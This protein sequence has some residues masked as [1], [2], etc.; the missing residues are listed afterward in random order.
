M[1]MEQ[2]LKTINFFLLWISND[3][4]CSSFVRVYTFF[5]HV[6]IW[7]SLDELVVNYFFLI[8]FCKNK[9]R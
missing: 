8:Y 2:Y 5:S 7:K 9:D 3:S 1:R 4:L 6:C